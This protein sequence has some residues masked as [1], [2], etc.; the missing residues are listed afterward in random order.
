MRRPSR[1]R[2]SSAR[3]PTPHSALAGSGCRN[4]SS[5]AA[6]TT[7]S[8]SGL[9][10]A[11]AILA[12]NLI[13]ATPTEQVMPCWSL[14][15]ALMSCA[16]RAG[17]PSRR[18]APATSRNASSS[19]SGSTSGVIERK[20]AMTSLETSPYSPCRGGMKTAC[21]NSRLALLTGIADRTPNARAS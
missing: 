7:S 5:P 18:C 14:T 16:I 11:D 15:C 9:Q 17:A 21:G 1:V 10:R 19:D 12:T 20:M 13:G 2:T 4:S 6:G 3:S 8:P